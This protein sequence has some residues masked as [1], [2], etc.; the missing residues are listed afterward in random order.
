MYLYS[1]GEK[2]IGMYSLQTSSVL[3]IWDL[4][5]LFILLYFRLGFCLLVSMVTYATGRDEPPIFL[6]GLMHLLSFF[7]AVS[8][9]PFLLRV[10]LGYAY[11]R[12]GRIILCF[13]V[14]KCRR[15]VQCSSWVMLLLY[16]IQV[17]LQNCLSFSNKKHY[18]MIWECSPSFCEI[19][20]EEVS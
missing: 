16:I 6:G 17:F 3:N 5:S 9:R 15:L 11:V 8:A 13:Q 20:A 4:R 19:T 10:I 1:V 2:I 14:Y 7:I 12:L 18:V